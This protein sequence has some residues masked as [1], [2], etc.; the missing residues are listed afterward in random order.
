MTLA[1]LSFSSL[2]GPMSLAVP[3]D[4]S[5][6]RNL[7][8]PFE[9]RTLVRFAIGLEDAGDLKADIEQA[10]DVLGRTAI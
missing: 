7:P 10:L 5:R 6:S 2:P 9:G 8:L 1:L 4:M 3:Y